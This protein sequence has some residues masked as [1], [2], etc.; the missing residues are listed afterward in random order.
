MGKPELAG[1]GLGGGGFH[2]S[3]ARR[4][5]AAAAEGGLGGRMEWATFSFCRMKTIH[6][7]SLI[8]ILVQSLSLITFRFEDAEDL[9]F[10]E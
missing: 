2:E 5:V 8:S 4:A 3:S 7:K 10:S 6:Q 1:L 9:K